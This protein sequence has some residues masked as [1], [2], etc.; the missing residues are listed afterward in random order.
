VIDGGTEGR[1][2]VLAGASDRAA[3]RRIA[4]QAIGFA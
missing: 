3:P 1:N 2:G 4:M